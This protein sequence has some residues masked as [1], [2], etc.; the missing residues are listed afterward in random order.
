MLLLGLK[1]LL[2]MHNSFTGS[3][4]KY[5]CSSYFE[6]KASNKTKKKISLPMEFT[7]CEG[8]KIINKYLE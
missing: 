2:A 7:F 4:N 1:K 8:Q 6:D 3:C 5:L